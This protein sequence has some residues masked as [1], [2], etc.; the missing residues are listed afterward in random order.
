MI[1]LTRKQKTTLINKNKNMQELT[2][3]SLHEAISSNP[4]IVIKFEASWCSSC[5]A[6]REMFERISNEFPQAKF[7]SIDLAN[8]QEIMDSYNIED[9]P[10][11]AVFKN[12]KEE[13]RIAGVKTEQAL[14]A[15]LASS[16]K[17]A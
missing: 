14:R 17:Q 9:L 10:T 11:I 4:A 3:A 7:A 2:K 16:L 5:Q 6:T 15:K 8:N 13:T 1:F 12:G